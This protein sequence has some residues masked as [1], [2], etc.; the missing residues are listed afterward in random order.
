MD[1]R[2]PFEGLFGNTAE[3]RILQFLLSLEGVGFNSIEL[4]QMTETSV[5]KVTKVADKF[6]KWDLLK[7]THDS[8]DLRQIRNTLY[9]INR[10]SEIV[11]AILNFDNAIIA[12][13]IDKMD[14]KDVH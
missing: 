3:L 13:L 11:K 1:N 6:V 10:D 9:Y 4:A 5:D 8:D 7:V 2:P 12:E 14:G